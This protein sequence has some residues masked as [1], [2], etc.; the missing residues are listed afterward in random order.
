MHMN[1]DAQ[2]NTSSSSSS[3]TDKELFDFLRQY[4][5]V[6]VSGLV[7]AFGGTAQKHAK[8]LNRLVLDGTIHKKGKKY[9]LSANAT[10]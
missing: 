1:S 3:Y 6:T 9:M 2:T 7:Y 5:Q 8:F 10:N 4:K